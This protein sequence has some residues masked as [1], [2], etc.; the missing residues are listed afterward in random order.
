MMKI[1][2]NEID[3]D[4]AIKFSQHDGLLL[5]RRENNMLLSDYQVSVLSRNG[6]SYQKYANIHDLLFDIEECL[7]DEYDDELDLV[8]SQIQEFIYYNETRK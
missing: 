2:N 5:K 6:L 8:G 4:E 3:I 7:C 1:K